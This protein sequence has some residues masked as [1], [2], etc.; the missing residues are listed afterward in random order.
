MTR[1][2]KSKAALALDAVPRMFSSIDVNY[3][4]LS[5]NDIL[6]EPQSFHEEM[7][8]LRYF[9]RFDALAA[10][11]IQR[12]VQFSA[13]TLHMTEHPD[14]LVYEPLRQAIERMLHAIFYDL[15]VN[16][17]AVPSYTFG[18]ITQ[19]R[20]RY[21]TI[22]DVWLRHPDYIRMHRMPNSSG[23]VVY[24]R[25]PQSDRSFILTKGTFP[26]GTK[27]PALY[28]MI[29]RQ[30]PEYVALI[31]SGVQEVRLPVTPILRTEQSYTTY[32]FPLLTP[33]LPALQHRYRLLELDRHFIARAVD[34][35][36][37]ISAGNDQFPVTE[38][39]TT[40]EDLQRQLQQRP[41]DDA[42]AKVY[43]LFTNHTVKMGWVLPP[44]DTLLSYDKYAAA[45]AD[46]LYALGFSRILLVGENERSNAGGNISTLGALQSIIS[47]QQAVLRWIKQTCEII[48]ER[49]R[50]STPIPDF[51][52][53]PIM[54]PEYVNF[55]RLMFEAADRE[56]ITSEQ[57]Q[58]ALPRIPAST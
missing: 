22:S 8:L 26:D 54:T 32:P 42:A 45:N 48:R 50:L 6:Q 9:A 20:K 58:A 21:T 1:L 40:L 12:M 25:I 15:Y 11:I 47:A 18:T 29:V 55:V 10:S 38:D 44:L 31:E 2:A 5:R 57:L 19:Q 56:L 7:R 35:I 27:D 53:D 23:Y 17:F 52:F 30:F 51:W 36:F 41:R 3:P 16:G 4:M 33:A 43:M 24:Y 49:N 39:D 13:R 37:H 34:A 14:A 28:D 46:V